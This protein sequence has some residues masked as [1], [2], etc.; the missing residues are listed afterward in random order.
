MFLGLP[1]RVT[2]AATDLLNYTT[3]AIRFLDMIL[4]RSFR[5]DTAINLATKTRTNRENYVFW[6]MG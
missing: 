5:G 4:N 2:I 3:L 6:V 1:S